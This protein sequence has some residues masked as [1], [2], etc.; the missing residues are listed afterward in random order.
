M[1]EEKFQ[2]NLAIGTVGEDVVYDWL[3]A[4]NSLV[5]N[6]RAQVHTKNRGPRLEGT[7]GS[8]ILPD[9]I[10]FNKNPSKGNF[11][12]DVKVKS[13]IYPISG[14][15]CFTVDENKFDDYMK[16]VAL[17]HLDHLKLIFLFEDRLYVYTDKENIGKKVFDNKYGGT[18]YLFEYDKSKIRY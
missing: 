6:T 15:M 17:M 1:T 3:K 4:N 8:V 16:C 2:E 14:K 11:A 5:Q 7:D 10:V 13:A 12:V 9:F 18:S